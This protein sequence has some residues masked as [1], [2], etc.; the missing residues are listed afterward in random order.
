MPHETRRYPSESEEY[1]KE[2]FEQWLKRISHIRSCD[3]QYEPNGAYTPPD[4]YLT[5]DGEKYA[6][7]V[8]IVEWHDPSVPSVSSTRW[9]TSFE[10]ICKELENMCSREGISSGY[11]FIL[12]CDPLPKLSKWK[13]YIRDKIMDYIRRNQAVSSA[14]RQA[15]T[16]KNHEVCVVTKEP[17]ET[18]KINLMG[19]ILVGP[20]DNF[21]SILRGE[22]TDKIGKLAGES[23]PC[24]LLLQD[25]YY[26]ANPAIW[27]ECIKN[28]DGKTFFHAIFVVTDDGDYM[29]HSKNPNWPIICKDR[30][31]YN[32][33]R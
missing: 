21:C 3:W 1:C 16:V 11:F 13:S 25:W 29:V 22:I 9:R 26:C 6:V 19:P 2:R 28:T 31:Y 23:L 10:H 24:I 12:L 4:Y 30:Y 32:G 7:E 27:D 18:L 20:E 8:A 14:P 33:M 15:I 5:L 17:S